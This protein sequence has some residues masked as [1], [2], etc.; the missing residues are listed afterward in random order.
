MSKPVIEWDEDYILSLPE[1][2]EFERKG[3]MLLDLKAGANE[4]DVLNELTKTVVRI[5]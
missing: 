3:A 5:R 1:N 2:D 4:D